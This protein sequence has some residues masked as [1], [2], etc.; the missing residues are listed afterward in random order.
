MGT[1][2]SITPED[3]VPVR[4]TSINVP[5][6]LWE[7]VRV[8]AIRRKMTATDAVEAALRTWVEGDGSAAA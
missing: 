6:D 1:E 3:R 2:I 5:A 4:R 8:V 7:E